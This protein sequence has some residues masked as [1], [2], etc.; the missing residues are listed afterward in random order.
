M[1]T[2]LKQEE[3]IEGFEL[4]NIS[5]INYRELLDSEIPE[6]IILSILSDLENEDSVKVVKLILA[7]LKRH[8]SDDTRLRKYIRQLEVLSRL[9]K[10]EE[11]TI[12]ASIDMPITYDIQTDYLYNKGKEVGKLEGKQEEQLIIARNI[13]KSKPFQQ[14]V[15]TYKDI[16]ESCNLSE[17]KIKA[18]H[19]SLKKDVN[20]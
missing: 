12:N 4:V 16:A 9:R 8:S 15:I 3:I 14:G 1:R 10:L 7:N 5:R 2:K 20:N 6:A 17:E 13:L 19:Q 18:L 11:V